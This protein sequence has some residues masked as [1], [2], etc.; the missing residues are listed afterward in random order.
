MLALGAAAATGQIEAFG[1]WGALAVAKN[2]RLG[3][4]GLIVLLRRR[5]AGG[6][7]AARLRSTGHARR[8]AASCSLAGQALLGSEIRCCAS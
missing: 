8:A 2:S 4:G 1:P 7:L 6:P 3:F 5:G